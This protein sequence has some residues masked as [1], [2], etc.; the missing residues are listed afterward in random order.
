V[1]DS[2]RI[3]I[4]PEYVQQLSSDQDFAAEMA[5]TPENTQLVMRINCF[6]RDERNIG[7]PQPWDSGTNQGIAP[8]KL[9]MEIGRG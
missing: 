4:A 6:G 8:A 9:K 3:L 2:A 1:Y 5:S 7:S